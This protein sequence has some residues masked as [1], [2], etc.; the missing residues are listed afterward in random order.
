MRLR[1]ESTTYKELSAP[2]AIRR[3]PYNAGAHCSDESPVRSKFLNAV[4]GAYLRDV[5]VAR[6]INCDSIRRFKF[7]YAGNEIAV[8]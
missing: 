7:S 3:G 6:A 1:P 2:I 4:L 5:N 8:W